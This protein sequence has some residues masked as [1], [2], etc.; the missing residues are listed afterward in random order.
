M[1]TSCHLCNS[2]LHKC[3]DALLDLAEQAGVLSGQGG[4]VHAAVASAILLLKQQDGQCFS[5]LLEA[6]RSDVKTGDG[7]EKTHG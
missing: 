3:G 6:A 2:L 4:M 5:T 1:N 7:R